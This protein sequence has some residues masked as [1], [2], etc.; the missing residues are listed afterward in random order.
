M[1]N[2]LDKIVKGLQSRKIVPMQVCEAEEFT[3]A[4]I[5]ITESVYIQI[6]DDYVYVFKEAFDGL[7]LYQ[8]SNDIDDIMT[9]LNKAIK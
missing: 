1:K 2:K 5:F 6:S 7:T 4:C 3:D 8:C 9:N